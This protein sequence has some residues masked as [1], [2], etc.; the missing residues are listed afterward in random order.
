MI[1]L[2]LLV[3]QIIWKRDFI[4]WWLFHSLCK[5][6]KSDQFFVTVLSKKVNKYYLNNFKIKMLKLYDK[7]RNQHLWQLILCD[8][9][10]AN[11]L[12]DIWINYSPRIRINL[13]LRAFIYINIDVVNLFF[14]RLGAF[15]LSLLKVT[16]AGIEI[17][18][19]EGEEYLTTN[20]KRFH[21]H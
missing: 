2:W 10:T 12:L 5:N 19:R 18:I 20:V 6:P 13:R 3:K 1:S 15:T 11:V 14:N 16:A 4:H 21:Y 9:D 8:N 7:F 17:C